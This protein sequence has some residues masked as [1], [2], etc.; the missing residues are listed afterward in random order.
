MGPLIKYS[1]H[2][3]LKVEDET[4]AKEVLN[5]YLRNKT[6][7]EQFEPTRPSDFYTIDYHAAMLRR[8]RIAYQMGTFLRYYIYRPYNTSRIIGAVNFNFINHEPVAYAEIGYKVDSLYQSQG[9]GYEAC[10]AAIRVIKYD[11]GFKRIDARIHPDNVASKKLAEK[12]GFK[13]VCLEEQSANVLGHYVD[14][15]RYSLDT[16]DIQ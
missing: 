8:E 10:L 11:Y 5:L 1:E 4:K 13:P 9:I 15:I 6:A 2:I 3:I 14:L 12:I 16:S 7:F